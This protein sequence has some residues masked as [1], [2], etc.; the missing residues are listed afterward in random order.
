[1]KKFAIF[2][3][4]FS[5]L[6]GTALTVQA[7]VKLARN[8]SEIYN[9]FR[10]SLGGRAG[11]LNANYK[12]GE[13]GAF[14]YIQNKISTSTINGTTNP[15]IVDTAT[16]PRE[17]MDWFKAKFLENTAGEGELS[18]RDKEGIMQAMKARYTD[19]C[20]AEFKKVAS[21]SLW[22]TYVQATNVLAKERQ[23]KI[24]SECMNGLGAC[25]KNAE[26]GGS[27]SI[28]LCKIDKDICVSQKYIDY[29]NAIKAKYNE[30]FGPYR[31]TL[32]NCLNSD[33]IKSWAWAR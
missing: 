5:L 2:I 23:S 12:S 32:N 13:Q 21:S 7:A 27:V 25:A 24:Q 26:A 10:G 19:F 15:S 8:K 22:K 30:I 20:Y 3:L 6:F 1:M 31:T 28:E 9:I 29:Q 17:K 16:G 4:L 14:D 33:Q 11:L 18:S